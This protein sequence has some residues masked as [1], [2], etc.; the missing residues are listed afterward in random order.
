MRTKTIKL[1]QFDELSDEAKEK[2]RD[3]YREVGFDYE[4]Y[5]STYEDAARVGLVIKG[6]DLYSR[7]IDGKLTVS[8]GECARRIINDHG[9]TCDTYKLAQDYFEAKHLGAPMDEE[10]FKR[11]LLGCYLSMLQSE[12]EYLY[13]NESVDETIRINEYEF[14]EDGKRA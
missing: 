12:M 7:T 6:F 3:W 1:Y 9:K 5:D 10:T 14:T 2:A 13:S 8:V 4:W 11:H